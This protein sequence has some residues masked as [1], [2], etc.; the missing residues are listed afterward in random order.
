MMNFHKTLQIKIIELP[1]LDRNQQ[2]AKAIS[3]LKEGYEVVLIQNEEKKYEGII[4]THDVIGKGINPAASCKTYMNKT[5]PS[6]LKEEL[7][8]VEQVGNYM[9]EGKSRFIPVL[10]EQ[11]RILGAIKDTQILEKMRLKF[12]QFLENS[13]ENVVNWDLKTLKS[14]DTIGNAIAKMREFGFSRIPIL[15]EQY[16]LQGIVMNRSLLKTQIEKKTTSGDFGGK[17]KDWHLLPVGDFISEIKTIKINTGILEVY[18]RIVNSNEHTLIIDDQTRYGIITA[19]DLIKFLLTSEKGISD[20]IINI[21]QAPD[22]EVQSHAIRKTQALL[23]REKRLLGTSGT[24]KIRFKRNMSQSKRGQYSI[25]ATIQ[26]ISDNG[27]NFSSEATDFGAEKAVN[28]ALDNISRIISNSK[29]RALEQRLK[30]KS[31]RKLTEL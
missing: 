15:D 16:E 27:H 10:D 22:D 26:L 31:L 29:K 2:L 6:I 9:L 18:D 13:L 25:T 1:R 19:L 14:S 7:I 24:V 21:L 8:S 3:L 4:R 5:V 23:N 20:Y 17:E 12:D 11:L 30:S 28:K